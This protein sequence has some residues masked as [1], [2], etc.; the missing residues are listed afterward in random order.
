MRVVEIELPGMTVTSQVEF[1]RN[2]CVNCRINGFS[3]LNTVQVVNLTYKALS[4]TDQEAFLAIFREHCEDFERDILTH[5]ETIPMNP[6]REREKPMEP[7]VTKETT[8]KYIPTTH[9]PTISADEF[10]QRIA[11]KSVSRQAK[12]IENELKCG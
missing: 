2:C 8:K 11:H 6:W 1:M 3:S 5:L 7:E 9:T 10:L 4:R 12:C